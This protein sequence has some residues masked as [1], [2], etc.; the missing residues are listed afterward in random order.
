MI[1]AV[2]TVKT[3]FLYDTQHAYPIAQMRGLHLAPIN[4][5]T[6]SSDGRMLVVCS[7]DGYVSFV[8]F[9]EGELGRYRPYCIDWLITVSAL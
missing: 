1:F 5:A 6:W 7:S 4:D 3:V 9:A 2:V 8:R